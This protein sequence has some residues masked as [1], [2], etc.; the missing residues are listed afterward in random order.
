MITDSF[1]VGAKGKPICQDYAKHYDNIA[2][3][4]DGCSSGA[5]SHIGATL[6]VRTGINKSVADSLGLGFEDMVATHL[7]VEQGRYTIHG[8]GTILIKYLDDSTEIINVHFSK[9]APDYPAYQL[10]GLKDQY[11]E[12][13]KGQDK[14]I[15]RIIDGKVS[16]DFGI[17]FQPVTQECKPFKYIMGFSDGIESFSKS[18]DPLDYNIIL[19]KMMEFKTIN[20]GFFHRR[21]KKLK[22]QLFKEGYDHFDD[23]SGVII[24]NE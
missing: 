18:D 24:Y 9:N 16:Y 11:L 12:M 22:E 20:E 4:S 6:M 3:L 13:F 8:D 15:T 19:I 2:I 7:R 5:E 1:Y 14:L 10:Y 21:F 17:P 23:I